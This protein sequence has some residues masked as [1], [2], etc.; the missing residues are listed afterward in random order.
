M[1]DAIETG[2]TTTRGSDPKGCFWAPSAV[3]S[4]LSFC[5]PQRRGYF[6]KH[7]FLFLLLFFFFAMTSNKNFPLSSPAKV[8]RLFSGSGSLVG[9]WQDWLRDSALGGEAEKWL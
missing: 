8:K 4:H 9:F 1:D 6:Q 7:D 5:W 3:L 2:I